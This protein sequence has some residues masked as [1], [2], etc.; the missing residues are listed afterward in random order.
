VVHLID[1]RF[2]RREIRQLLPSWW[3]LDEVSAA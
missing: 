1:D 3:A 2:S